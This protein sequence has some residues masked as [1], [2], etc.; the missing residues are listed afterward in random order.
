MCRAGPQD[1]RLVSP[2]VAAIIEALAGADVAHFDETGFR[3]AGKLA[4]VHSASAGKYALHHC[5]PQ[6]GYAR[7]WTP[8]GCCRPSPASPCHDAWAPYDTYKG[9]PRT[10]CVTLTLL[11]ELTAVTETGTDDDMVSA[12]QAIDV[13]LTP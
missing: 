6:A 12:S 7:R 9:V 2:A 11:R 1:R 4:W 5:S 3:V 8:P 10:L 13:L